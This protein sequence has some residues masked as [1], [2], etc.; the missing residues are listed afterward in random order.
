VDSPKRRDPRQSARSPR[1]VIRN[2]ASSI[3]PV[4][5][6]LDALDRVKSTGPGTWLA[7][8]PTSAHQHGDR[9]RGLAI[10]EGDDGRVLIH[11]FAGCAVDAVIAALGLELHDLFQQREITYPHQ[12]P[13]GGLIGHPRYRRIPW[14]DL[15]EALEHQLL[16]CSMAFSD[17]A[18]GKAFT[19]EDAEALSRLAGQLATEIMEVR[20]G[21]V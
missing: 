3:P 8:C 18:K 15:F 1:A 19:T 21:R 13:K 2:S 7:S 4:H 14:A 6:V 17:L 9:S 20:H 16:V 11:C 5:R 12:S 10:R